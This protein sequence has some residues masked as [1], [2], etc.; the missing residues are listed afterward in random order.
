MIYVENKQQNIRVRLSISVVIVNAHKLKSPIKRQRSTEWTKTFQ[1][2][3]CLQEASFEVGH[4]QVESEIGNYIPLNTNCYSLDLEGPESLCV[5]D[6]EPRLQCFQ[7][8]VQ[9]LGG[10]TQCKKVVVE[11]IPFEE[12]MG[13][14]L[15]LIFL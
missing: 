14:W 3:A 11:V 10:E 7:E 8:V 1:A 12:D 4:K 6:L 2:I 5:E 9:F 15:L 13:S